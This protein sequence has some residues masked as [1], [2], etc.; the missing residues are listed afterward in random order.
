ME[1]IDWDVLPAR[2]GVYCMYDLDDTPVYVGS[3][4]ESET[5]HL[6]ARLREHFTQQN[7][8]VVAHARIDLLDIWYVDYWATREYK[9]AEKQL[10]AAQDPVFNRENPTV[11]S[12]PIDVNNPD[13]TLRICSDAE[14]ETRA[15]P[16]NR[17]RAKMDHIQRMIDSDQVALRSISQGHSKRITAARAAVDYH[18]SVLESEIENHYAAFE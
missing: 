15:K 1:S 14:R 16:Q 10:I 2:G 8:S 18:L 11:S 3:A 5:R 7:T 9:I 13:G 6:K 17:I 4:S 12:S